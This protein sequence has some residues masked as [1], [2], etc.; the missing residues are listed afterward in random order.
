VAI[1]EPEEKPA[2]VTPKT[3]E[4]N[5]K[6]KQVRGWKEVEAAR[7]A[8][9]EALIGRDFHLNYLAC[10]DMVR[11]AARKEERTSAI[12]E[13]TNITPPRR[14]NRELLKDVAPFAIALVIVALFVAAGFKIASDEEKMNPQERNQR[15]WYGGL[16]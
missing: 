13:A 7:E 9:R 1:Y 10:R 4:E 12:P 16:K 2:D 11:A 14:S 5:P 15:I 3:A 6:G 8:E